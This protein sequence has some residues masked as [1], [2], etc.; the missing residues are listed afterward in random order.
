MDNQLNLFIMKR[1][2][3]L[4]VV[5]LSIV[6]ACSKVELEQ[7]FNSN[8]SPLLSSGTFLVSNNWANGTYLVIQDEEEFKQTYLSLQS[9][10]ENS[11]ESEEPCH[12]FQ[13]LDNFEANYSGF[14]SMRRW[15]QE[16][17]CM[18]FENDNAPYMEPEDIIDMP[19]LDDVKGT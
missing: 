12:P 1:L 2:T 15:Y 19:Y 8:S 3:A 17:E 9:Q 11:E 10:L 13:F 7:E 5:V 6:Y 14:I 4:C 18:W 16:Y